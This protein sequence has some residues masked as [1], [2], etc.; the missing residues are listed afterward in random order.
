MLGDQAIAL[1]PG[2]AMAFPMQSGFDYGQWP[3]IRRSGDDGSLE[4]VQAHWEFLAP[5]LRTLKEVEISRQKYTTMN[6]VGEK[7]LESRLYREAALQRRCLVL[8]SGFY[9]WR[10]WKAPGEKKDRAIPYFVFLP[11]RELFYIAGVWQDWTDQET[12]EHRTGFALL[13]TA[14]NSLMEQV[15]NKK[16]RM[17][18]ILDEVHALEWLAAG[19]PEP[20]IRELATFQFDSTYMDAYTIQKDFRSAV[21]PVEPFVYEGLPAL[22]RGSV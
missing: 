16:K 5:W 19:L 20:R 1:P 22:T 9:E 12:G 13:T 3:I 8:S 2:T 18:L 11:T 6:A 21:D 17:P 7:I 10:H 15:H 14:A 4:V